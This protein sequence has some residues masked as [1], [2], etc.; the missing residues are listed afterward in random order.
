MAS[1][2]TGKDSITK[3]NTNGND[4]N[5]HPNDGDQ[6]EDNGRQVNPFDIIQDVLPNQVSN[7]NIPEHG[8]MVLKS[9]LLVPKTL[10]VRFIQ[11]YLNDDDCEGLVD[12]T[13]TMWK[14]TFN[15]IVKTEIDDEGPPVTKRWM[16]KSDVDA[17]GGFFSEG[18]LAEVGVETNN[19]V[20]N[21]S[22]MFLT[23]YCFHS[24][25]IATRQSG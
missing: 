3:P 17:D 24:C 1:N 4:S 8:F 19:I 25:M 11:K 13:R 20:N 14:P 23:N 5:P 6:L 18:L 15:E 21:F 9:S 12:Q 22:I 16:S 7:Y 2:T 10:D